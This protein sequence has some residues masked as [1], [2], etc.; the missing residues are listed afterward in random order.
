MIY[1]GGGAKYGRVVGDNVV[2]KEGGDYREWC[3]IGF[4]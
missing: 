2:R 3:I 1:Q 4:L